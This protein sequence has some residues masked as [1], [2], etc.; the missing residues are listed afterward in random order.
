MAKEWKAM[1]P[2]EKIEWLYAA[3]QSL[4][5]AIGAA[6]DD[7]SGLSR[8]VVE[9]DLQQKSTYELTNEVVATVER[10]DAGR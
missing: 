7:L 3:L 5:K 6:Q 4:E 10:I 2:D 8:R 1:S 9:L